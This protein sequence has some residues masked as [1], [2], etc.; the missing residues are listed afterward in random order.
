M[1]V[2][3]VLADFEPGVAIVDLE[4]HH[5]R[6]LIGHLRYCGVSIV[7]GS[8]CQAHARE[9]FTTAELPPPRDLRGMPARTRRPLRFVPEPGRNSAFHID[10]ARVR[11][12]R[13]PRAQEK[14]I[15]EEVRGVHQFVVSPGAA[16]IARQRDLAAV[17][18]VAP[19]RTRPASGDDAE[20]SIPVRAAP[21]SAGKSAPSEAEGV[22]SEARDP[23][24]AQV[25][26]LNLEHAR[27]VEPKFH[28]PVAGETMILARCTVPRTISAVV[29]RLVSRFVECGRPL[30]TADVSAAISEIAERRTVQIADIIDVVAGYFEIDPR[31]MLSSRRTA[32]IVLPRQIAMYFAKTLTLRS[33]PEIGR[34][35][36]GRDHTTVL[37]A[38]RKIE[39]CTA[40]D[41]E[42]AETI[43]ALRTQIEARQ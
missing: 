24:G 18:S 27:L 1:S 16:V 42:M 7:S 34:R 39:K 43:A 20:H 10:P 41:R 12:S 22:G 21:G 4:P 9:F 32:N 13:C 14:L 23:I 28:F 6:A 17:I 31:D 19:D 35:F 8:F 26:S 29:W 11:R 33:L 5:C 15:C 36:C 3:E 30:V 25:L 2:A 40:T 37:H 38:V